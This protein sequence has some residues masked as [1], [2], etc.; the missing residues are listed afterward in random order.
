MGRMVVQAW[1]KV[2]ARAFAEVSVPFDFFRPYSEPFGYDIK[3]LRL[4]LTYLV[5]FQAGNFLRGKRCEIASL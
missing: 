4:R 3:C 5:P 2:M 1:M